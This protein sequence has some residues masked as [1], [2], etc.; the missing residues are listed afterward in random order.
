M[1]VGQIGNFEP[2]HSTENELRKALDGLGHTVVTLQENDPKT[3]DVLRDRHRVTEFD[4]V[5]WTRTW[6][7]HEFGLTDDDQ[8][9][10]LKMCRD[11][12]VPTVGYHLDRWW[13]LNREHE[14]GEHPFFRCDLVITADGGH[15]DCWAAAGVNHLWMPPGVSLYECEPGTPDDR[16]VSDIAFVG[17]WQGYHPEWQ[18]RPQLIRFLQRR[19]A[20]QVR[21]WP[22]PGEHAVRGAPLRDLYASV[23][24]LIGDSCLVPGVGGRTMSRYI[25][26]RVPETLGRGGFLIHPHVDGVTDG[27]HYTAGTHLA[28]WQL[29]DWETLTELIRHY[30]AND[31]ERTGIAAAGRAHVLEHHTYTRRM[32]Q[33]ID[34]LTTR[35]ML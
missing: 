32:E 30:L 4:M 13:G 1:I 25:S 19:F 22:P 20:R 7:A 27:T 17:S 26:D 34:T 9:Q 24:V 2:D 28:T 15:D 14:I 5:L 35:G 23:K 31:D 12:D 8:H 33:V 10:A 18:H 11:V 16:F 3:W 6:R 29:G 21:F